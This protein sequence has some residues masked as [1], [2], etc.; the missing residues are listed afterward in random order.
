MQ[1]VEYYVKGLFR[2]SG[3]G[4]KLQEQ[5][6]E[7]TNHLQERISDLQESG[8]DASE[9]FER[10]V[11]SLGNI[12]EL[13]DT[14][15]GKKIRVPLYK[16]KFI[17][18]LTGFVY[19]VVYFACMLIFFLRSYPVLSAFAILLPGFLAYLLPFI[20][21]SVRYIQHK[22]SIVVVNLPNSKEPLFSFLGWLLIS[23]IC[24]GGNLLMLHFEQSST[25]WAWMPTMGVFTWPLMTFTNFSFLKKE[26]KKQNES[27]F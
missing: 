22:N 25:F 24:I 9:S 13:I 14:I 26:S 7:L 16:I 10:A 23:F 11:S 6:E 15:T 2:S 3:G 18:M 21:L 12:D 1:S 19:G 8:L 27:I 5:I 20:Y 4:E 17:E